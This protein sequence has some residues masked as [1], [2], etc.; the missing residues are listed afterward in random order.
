MHDD[1]NGNAYNK[2]M[3]IYKIITYPFCHWLG[4]Y[5]LQQQKSKAIGFTLMLLTIRS[6]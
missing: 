1:G 2:V 4:L 6:Y 5:I 3:Q